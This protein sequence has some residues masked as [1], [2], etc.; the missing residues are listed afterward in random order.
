MKKSCV[1]YGMPRSVVES[2][3]SDETASLEN[4]VEK[5]IGKL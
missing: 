5:I 1:F 2:G 3:L 4:M